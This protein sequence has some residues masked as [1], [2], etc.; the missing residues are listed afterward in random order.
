[1]LNNKQ[2]IAAYFYEQV[3]TPYKEF[4]KCRNSPEIGGGRDLRAALNAAEAIYHFREQLGDAFRPRYEDITAECPDYALTRDVA[5]IA[6]HRE[7]DRRSAQLRAADAI[8]EMLVTTIYE[9]ALGEYY[10]SVKEFK[11]RL[12]NGTSRDL[13]EVLTNSFNFWCRHLDA[14]HVTPKFSEFTMPN[15]VKPLP[16][17]KCQSIANITITKGLKF[18]PAVFQLQRYNYSTGQVHP[19]NL[20]GYKPILRVFKPKHEVDLVLQNKST[21][22]KLTRTIALNPDQSKEFDALKSGEE[23]QK[24][25]SKIPQV[26]AALASLAREAAASG[27]INKSTDKGHSNP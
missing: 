15:T 12:I 8:Q 10:N 26:M 11:L 27:K 17:V 16:R 25:L 22:E 21:G 9:D 5:D 20:T 3:V 6:K 23:R 19:M 14:Q 4:I 18:G 1:M 7:L 24:Y 2:D 13:S